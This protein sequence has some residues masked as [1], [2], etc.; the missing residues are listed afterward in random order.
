MGISRSIAV[1]I[2]ASGSAPS[3]LVASSAGRVLKEE[4]L[5]H[6]REIAEDWY[7]ELRGKSRAGLLKSEKTLDQAADQFL[8]EYAIITE[9]Q[10]SPRW[11]EGHKIR[12]RLHLRP[13][14]GA[15]GNDAAGAQARC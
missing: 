3:R 11:V 15:L 10:R 12:V 9:G 5:A 4:S 2:V 14:F 13:F 1:P 8:K 6:A 7:L